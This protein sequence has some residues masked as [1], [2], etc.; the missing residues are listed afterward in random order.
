MNT[1]YET[2]LSLN[3]TLINAYLKMKSG[4]TLSER[5]EMLTEATLTDAQKKKREEIVLAMKKESESLQKRYGKD[6]ESVMYAT[7][8]K[9]ALAEAILAEESELVGCN[10]IMI[11]KHIKHKFMTVDNVHNHSFEPSDENMEAVHSH[12]K[13]FGFK[14]SGTS[15]VTGPATETTYTHANGMKAYVGRN[16]HA[17]WL[18]VVR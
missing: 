2:T 18:D 16:K 7:A 4:K 9:Q 6:W 3:Q 8:T 15:D 1:T 10:S 13:S 11:P 12:L 5:H 17:G 14:Q